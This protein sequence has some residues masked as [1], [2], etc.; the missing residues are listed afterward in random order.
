MERPA[1]T[2]DHVV[3]NYL[4]KVDGEPFDGGEGRD[5]LL[6]LGSGRLIP[7]FEEQLVGAS[8]GDERQVAVTFP[9]EY[10]NELGGKD[11]TFDVTLTEVKEKRL[12]ELER[13]IR[14]RVGG[15][16]QPAGAARGRQHPAA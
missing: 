11:A 15:L 3:I 4:G 7:G 9:E 14:Q 12:P 16:R 13:R 10:P 6:E 2:G 8:A 1:Q 5:Q